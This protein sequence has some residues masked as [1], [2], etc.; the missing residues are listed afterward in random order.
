MHLLVISRHHSLAERVRMAFEGA[1]HTV[2][3]HEDALEALANE[4]WSRA[5]LLLVDA[6]GDPLDGYRFCRLLRGE[7][8][9][10]FQNLPIY[11][12]QEAEPT[13]DD[14]HRL[15]RVGADGFIL[16]GQSIH[17]LLNLLGPVVEGMLVRQDEPSVPVVALGLKP[18]QLRQVR[19]S[20]HHFRFDLHA[21]PPSEA[22]STLEALR[23]PLLLHGLDTGGHRTLERLQKL[24]DQGTLPYT[25]LLGDVHDESMQRKLLLAGVADWLPMPLSPPRLLHA[26]RRGL[27]WARI[28]AIQREYEAAVHGLRDQRAMLEIEA[29]SLRT[30]VLTDPLTG[31]LNRR[32]FDQNLEF[33]FHA[34]DRHG[35]SFVLVLG[36]LDHFKLIND[37]FGHPA[38]DEVLKETAIRLRLSLRRSDLAFRIGGEEFALLLP[39]TSLQ[40]G[41][42]VAEKLRKTI[43]DE[44]V[45]LSH[46]PMVYPSMS[47]GVA[48]AQGRDPGDVLGEAD[49]ALYRAKVSGRNRVVVAPEPNPAIDAG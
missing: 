22:S 20:L 43:E 36:D 37:R 41:A 40:A 46:G 27:E 17:D 9:I 14:Q 26:C 23:A 49:R 32:A 21:P 24:R 3:H 35:R 42:E 1:G 30:Q 29:T 39:E 38:G 6:D 25:I 8:R 15:E 47:F 5:H 12:V 45:Q 44:P 28:K 4:S 13:E 31:L 33:T 10:F 11:L 2:E 7:S 34:W 18:D 16:A 19:E 48:A